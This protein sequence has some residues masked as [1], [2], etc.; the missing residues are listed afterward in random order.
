M[1]R[2]LV[3]PR[4]ARPESWPQGCAGK[5]CNVSYSRMWDRPRCGLHGRMLHR[6]PRCRCRISVSIAAQHPALRKS[7]VTVVPAKQHQGVSTTRKR[8]R[9]ETEPPGAEAAKSLPIESTIWTKIPHASV[10]RVS[11][12]EPWIVRRP[13]TRAVRLGR[14]G[15]AWQ[16]MTRVQ[17]CFVVPMTRAP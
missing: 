8:R 5:M 2:P 1:C 10:R 15:A 4:W 17:C 9:L 3:R 12:R 13:Q 11:C 16:R 14:T 7:R 6:F